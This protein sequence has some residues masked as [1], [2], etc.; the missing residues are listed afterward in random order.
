MPSSIA[1]VG[2]IVLLLVGFAAI[3]VVVGGLLSRGGPMAMAPAGSLYEAHLVDG[4]VYLGELTGDTGGYVEL[5][6]PAIV[7]PEGGGDESTYRVVSLTNDP[8]AIVGPV[9]IPR[10]QIL[11]IGA[12]AARTSIEQAYLDAI[13]KGTMSPSPAPS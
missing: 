4:S 10:E 13:A 12:V 11:V 9:L 8:Y 1:R 2:T 5:S 3:G 7:L 6:A